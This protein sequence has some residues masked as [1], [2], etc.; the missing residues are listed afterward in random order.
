MKANLLLAAFSGFIGAIILTLLMYMI[1]ASGQKLDIP[2]LLGSRFV[3]ITKTAKVYLVGNIIHLLIGAAWGM[4]Y[5]ALLKGLRIII[6]WPAGIL[7]GLA[8][9]IFMGVMMGILE[10]KHP[11][12]G[13]DKSIPNPGILG[14]KWGTA[15][16]YYILGLH[17]IFGA[18]TLYVY[19]WIVMG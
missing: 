17:I 14:R 3:D 7:W 5:V 4:L 18:S 12:I 16:P 10:K 11:H 6:N 8:H 19:H 13:E 2:Y 9:G 1:K 15:I